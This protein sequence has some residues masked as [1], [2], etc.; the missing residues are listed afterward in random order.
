MRK[1]KLSTTALFIFNIFILDASFA[2]MRKEFAPE[3]NYPPVVTQGSYMNEANCFA[4]YSSDEERELRAFVFPGE[5][6]KKK[7]IYALTGRGIHF[8]PI[9][10]A[11]H[12]DCFEAPNNDPHDRTRHRY[13]Q[14]Y[15]QVN[16]PGAETY[17]VTYNDIKDQSPKSDMAN[18]DTEPRLVVLKNPPENKKLCKLANHENLTAESEGDLETELVRR[19][20]ETHSDFTQDTNELR[21]LRKIH[22]RSDFPE[23]PAGEMAYKASRRVSAASNSTPLP[24]PQSSINQIRACSIV[25]RKRVQAV[26]DQQLRKFRAPAVAPAPAPSTKPTNQ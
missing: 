25:H 14:Y 16:L 18:A 24:N 13:N 20:S 26:V 9:S 11:D 1:N 4:A 2:Q 21:T 15:F 19:I 23:G 10:Q 3:K 5:Q 17:Y 12:T 8:F 7:G 22:E 6:N